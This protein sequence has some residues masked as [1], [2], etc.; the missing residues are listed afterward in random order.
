MGYTWRFFDQSQHVQCHYISQQLHACHSRSPHICQTLHILLKFLVFNP[1][2]VRTQNS[3]STILTDLNLKVGCT[4][5]LPTRRYSPGVLRLSSQ[6]N[7]N[8]FLTNKDCATS[9]KKGQLMVTVGLSLPDQLQESKKR[10]SDMSLLEYRTQIWQELRVLT[11]LVSRALY[12]CQG[13][14]SSALTKKTWEHFV[15]H[16]HS[17]RDSNWCNGEVNKRKFQ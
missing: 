9:S 17:P 4:M 11:V 3:F 16:S 12:L 5:N 1:A 7:L 13:R 6:R 2:L 14:L 8:Q 10:L 15:S